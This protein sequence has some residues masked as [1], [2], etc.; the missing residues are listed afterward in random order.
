MRAA[1]Y[2]LVLVSLL[3]E[4]AQAETVFYLARPRAVGK[5]VPP[6]LL[7]DLQAKLKA[8][9]K[10]RNRLLVE[11]EEDAQLV[12]GPEVDRRTLLQQIQR[13][14][15]AHEELD[16]EAARKALEQVI[17]DV[18]DLP[19]TPDA[20]EV[21]RD[22]MILQTEI[23]EAEQDLLLRDRTIDQ[24]LRVIPTIQPRQRGLTGSLA[25]LVVARKAT[26]RPAA[27][28]VLR[29]QPTDAKAWVD[30][31]PVQSG[32][33]LRP[34]AHR[35]LVRAAGHRAHV[36]A[37]EVVEGAGSVVLRASLRPARLRSAVE[38]DQALS[39]QATRLE[40][41]P[42]MGELVRQAAA[43]IG[44]L[45]TIGRRTDGRF[46]LHITAVSP[47]GSV[48]GVGKMVTG[49]LLAEN[50]LA[51]LLSAASRKGEGAP[52]AAGEWAAQKTMQADIPDPSSFE[53][54][55]V[56]ERPVS[57]PSQRYRRKGSSAN[58]WIVTTVALLGGSAAY[59]IYSMQEPPT[60]EVFL[61]PTL[62][63]EVTLP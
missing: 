63:V 37:F 11:G 57:M 44:W 5:R 7:F 43:Q 1:V 8:L 27:R 34:G 38:L 13:A 58:L 18:G 45:A 21:W 42:R 46:D 12:T 20:R 28:A 61:D 56:S 15:S 50:D 31:R 53:G 26:L 6:S 60:E 30:G 25:D 10:R 23:A 49:G 35:L 62:S 24:L 9:I 59:L 54:L 2:T 32:D 16:L 52:V 4:V 29:L 51:H 47:D 3:S 48:A 33:T 41:L 17:R 19:L 40:V 22:V 36:E 14:R 39:A 55:P